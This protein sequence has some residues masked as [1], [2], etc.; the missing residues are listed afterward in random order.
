L[1]AC[2]ALESFSDRFMKSLAEALARGRD[3]LLL[4]EYLMQQLDYATARPASRRYMVKGEVEYILFQHRSS[5]RNMQ[6]AAL[7]LLLLRGSI[8]FVASL[9][10]S[11]I[12]NE[13]TLIYALE[14]GIRK[15]GRDV[16]RLF[17]GER[18]PA[19]P[20]QTKLTLSYRDHLRLLLLCQST[21]KQLTGLQ[22]LIQTNLWY[23]AAEE[24]AAE[25][26]AASAGAAAAG[27][28]ESFAPRRYAAEIV[29]A[30]EAEFPLWPLGR[31]RVSRSAKAGYDQAFTLL[32]PEGS[33]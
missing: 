21:A 19:F 7:D 28:V 23:W 20:G 12:I 22:K 27:A 1:E 17:A 4:S 18:I 24:G 5:W 3:K 10:D 32:S 30:A 25:E 11:G 14:E 6:Q 31:L 29:A 9:A 16:E 15:G 13:A 8:H 26:G 33:G 2:A